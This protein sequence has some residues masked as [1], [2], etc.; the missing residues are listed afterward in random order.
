MVQSTE[1]ST[2]TQFFLLG[3]ER[4]TACRAERGAESE[5]KTPE[6]VVS[7]GPRRDVF[8][9]RGPSSGKEPRNN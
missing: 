5:E 3:S 9:N 2:Q 6:R 4:E 8:L 7:F 1:P